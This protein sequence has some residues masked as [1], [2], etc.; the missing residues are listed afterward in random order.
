MEWTRLAISP[1]TLSWLASLPERATEGDC[2]L[3]HGSLREPLWEY[4]TSERVAAQNIELLPE[5]I[6]IGLHGHTHMPV[7][8]VAGPSDDVPARRGSLA[9]V[10]GRPGSPLELEG[11]T[12]LVNP[13]SVGQPRDGDPRASYLLFEPEAARATWRR[14]AYDIEAVQKAMRA[15]GL[16]APLAARLSIGV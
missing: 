15:A 9:T 7:A 5:S 2:A 3:V 13:G 6:R 14:V 1:E 12:A 8:F 10:R 16:P 11:R 4:V